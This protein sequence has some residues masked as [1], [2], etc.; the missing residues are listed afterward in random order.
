M[1]ESTII[2]TTSLA[3]SVRHLVK[4]YLSTVPAKEVTHLHSM[5]MEHV[6]TALLETVMERCRRNQSH[7]ATILGISRGTCRN[8]LYRYFD[9]QYF[10][11]RQRKDTQ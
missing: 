2:E 4:T 7:T 8:M 10:G 1:T 3:K 5:V 9:N 6:E 11:A